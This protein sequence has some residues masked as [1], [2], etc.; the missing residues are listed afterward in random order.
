M[1][2]PAVSA[3]CAGGVVLV[4]DRAGGAPGVS[5]RSEQVLGAS[6]SRAKGPGTSAGAFPMALSL[7]AENTRGP[8]R[9]ANLGP[10]GRPQD[11]SS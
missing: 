3:A 5:V 4:D 2:V 8:R 6:Y 7:A 11:P 10:V 1:A 9:G